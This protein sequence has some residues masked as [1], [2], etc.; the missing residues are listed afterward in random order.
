MGD[1]DDLYSTGVFVIHYHPANG[2]GNT[3]TRSG[4]S[5]ET[6]RM[7]LHAPRARTCDMSECFTL[8]FYRERNAISEAKS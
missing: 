4:G 5:R 1:F 7:A 6:A 8:K 2:T 3:I